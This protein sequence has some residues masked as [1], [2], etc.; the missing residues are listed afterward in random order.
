MMR[1][2]MGGEGGLFGGQG[3]LGTDDDLARAYERVGR[4]L[5]DLPY[6]PDFLALCRDA[7]LNDAD[8][9]V[10]R[11]TLRRLQRLRKSGKLARVGKAAGSPPAV[12]PKEEELL[13]SLVVEAAGSLGQRDQLPYSP[14]FDALVERFNAACGRSLDPHAVWRLVAKLAK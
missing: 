14:A 3:A 11:E 9:A 13:T 6:T 1:W 7:G 10:L 12:S 8:P 5:D 4:T 2:S